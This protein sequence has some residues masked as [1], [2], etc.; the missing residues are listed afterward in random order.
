MA[1][2]TSLELELPWPPSVNHLWRRGRRGMFKSRNGKDFERQCWAIWAAAGSP[3]LPAG[4]PV[5]VEIEL[6]PPDRRRRDIDN[7]AKAVLDAL[8]RVG[9]IEDDSLVASLSIRRLDGGPPGVRVVAALAA[10]RS[11]P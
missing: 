8:V 2:A 1:T 7:L 11:A 9:A 4:M 10:E 6:R 5:T 3:V